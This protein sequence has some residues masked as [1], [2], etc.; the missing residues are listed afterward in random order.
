MVLTVSVMLMLVSTV[1]L[2]DG[3]DITV[4]V[5]DKT[6]DF[7]TSQNGLPL[8]YPEMTGGRTMLPL[9]A[10]AE[11]GLG[12][13]V[14]WE[15]K[16]KTATVK[17]GNTTVKI[18]IGENS[19]IVNG[20]RV[21]I[22]TRVDSNG[23]RVAV[24]TKAYLK[25]GRTFVPARFLAEA[26]GDEVDYHQDKIGGKNHHVIIINLKGE[27]NT[28]GKPTPLPVEEAL[29]PGT[30]TGKADYSS[31]EALANNIKKVNGYFGDKADKQGGNWDYSTTGTLGGMALY[32]P[33]GT[34]SHNHFFYV[35]SSTGM[36]IDYDVVISINSW[37]KP[38]HN[39][40]YPATAEV[41]KSINPEVKEVLK[42]Y[43]PNG[44]EKL[45]KGLDEL[46]TRKMSESDWAEY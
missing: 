34:Y 20:T 29:K 43:L 24:D 15:Q 37:H 18:T 17:K 27:P 40:I 44:Y 14:T 6:I 31:P 28:Q 23:K 25:D 46:Y 7:N 12:Y 35:Q 4:L 45:Y 8:G 42:F 36:D 11:D 5:D 9:R 41:Y 30:L 32:N 2:A 1:A 10:G 3:N 16:S 19:A 22:D 33:I 39:D 26:M 38:G 13:N 21:A